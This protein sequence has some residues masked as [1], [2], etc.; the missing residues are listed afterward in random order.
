[1]R[2]TELPHSAAFS[3]FL[4]SPNDARCQTRI[5]VLSDHLSETC[6]D[7]QASLVVWHRQGF[8]EMT[9]TII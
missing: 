8:L 2:E 3:F 6:N 4:L 5:L 7:I 9:V 1:M